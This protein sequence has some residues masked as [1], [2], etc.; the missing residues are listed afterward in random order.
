ME[1]RTLGR[2]GLQVP[3]LAFGGNV[4]GWTVDRPTSFSI[5]DALLDNGLNF[6]D[7]ADEYS[8]WAAGNQ[9]GESE[10]LIGEW[11]KKSGNRDRIILAT[12]V[13]MP[14]GAG[15]KGLSAAYIRQAVTDSLRRLQ[16][17]YIDLYQAHTDD[18]SVC[19][20]ETLSAFDALIKEGKVRVIG[21]SNYSGVRLA[22]ALRISEQNGLAR[23]ECLQPE[24]N[25]YDRRMFEQDLQ[26]VVAAH[27]VGVINYYALASGFLSG[28]YR[29]KEDAGKSARGATV[30]ERYL[31]ARGMQILQAL[32]AISEAY[33]V[34]PAQIALAW[35]MK[36]PTITAPIASATSLAQLAE[37]AEATRLTLSDEDYRTLDEASAG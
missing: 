15:K 17:E 31:N 28:K 16:T 4:F 19:L 7:T 27:G 29:A 14:M 13:G 6:I 24:F 20:E 33:R 3:K 32:D 26:P 21:V 30:I 9:G 12:K 25:L 23:Y 5:L 11:L 8:H 1:Q 35:Q 18:A 37:L 2:S 22:E 10:T 34:T 36:H